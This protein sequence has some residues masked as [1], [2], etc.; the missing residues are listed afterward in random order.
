MTDYGAEQRDELE[1]IESI[2][3]EEINI[4]STSPDKIRFLDTGSRVGNSLPRF[5]IPVKTDDYDEEEGGD[6]GLWVLLKFTFPDEYPDEAP[7]IEVEEE[8][9]LDSDTRAGMIP[10]LEGVAQENLGMAMVF[11]IVSEGLNWLAETNDRIKS[12]EEA[13]LKAIKDAVDAEEQRKL[14]G[15]KVTM[16]SFLAW[17]L[18]FDADMLKQKGPQKVKKGGKKNGRELFLTDTSLVDS[19]V[20]FLAETGD[21]AVTVDESLFEDLDDLDL[22][23][24]DEDDPDWKAGDSDD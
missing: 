9:N 14:E 21:T 11:T 2:Y 7:G 10:Y 23:D 15:T 17:K 13:R 16:E 4:I 3:S 24:D 22:D 5:T 20:K 8:E 1:A 12:D 6:E 19:D 18:E